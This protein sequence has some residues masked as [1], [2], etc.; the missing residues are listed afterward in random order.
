[1]ELSHASSPLLLRS[2]TSIARAAKI[3][4]AAPG[5]STSSPFG[6]SGRAEIHLVLAGRD[7]AANR[8][9][10]RR[11][12]GLE[13]GKLERL[14]KV[15]AHAGLGSR[16]GCE[17]LILQGRVSV[18]GE[19]VR[20]L[21]TRVDPA[22]ARITVDGEPIRLETMVYYAVNKPKGYVSTNFDPVGPSSRGRPASRDSRAGLHRRPSRRGQHRA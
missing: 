18:D 7:R 5:L 21:G 16:R 4:A 19:V 13:P 2:R 9:T 1:M 6:R 8:G 22:R 12:A 17:Q 11:P 14:Q 20:Q 10:P 3:T 15:L